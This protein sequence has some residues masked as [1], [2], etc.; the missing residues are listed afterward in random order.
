MV[1]LWVLPGT[2]HG[3]ENREE[4]IG[5]YRQDQTDNQTNRLIAK[6]VIVQ[7]L[8][9]F[10][11]DEGVSQPLALRWTQRALTGTSVRPIILQIVSSTSYMPCTV[12][13]Q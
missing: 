2:S 4:P 11:N 10:P 13:V 7:Y 1:Q 9:Y 5:T 8:E 6:T 12:C 3:R